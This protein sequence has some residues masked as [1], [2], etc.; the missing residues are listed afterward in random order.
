[1]QKVKRLGDNLSTMERDFQ[2]QSESF[3][4]V[5]EG[6]GIE[7]AWENAEMRTED[8]KGLVLGVHK[9]PDRVLVVFSRG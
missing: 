6:Q 4:G 7:E 8:R 5:S 2:G 1:M 9:A 3:F